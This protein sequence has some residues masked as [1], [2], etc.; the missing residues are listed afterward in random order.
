MTTEKEDFWK[1][2]E[3]REDAE[4]ALKLLKK[5]IDNPK[6]TSPAEL[7]V[8]KYKALKARERFGYYLAEDNRAGFVYLATNKAMSGLVKIG[9]TNGDV[10]ERM[11][12]LSSNT[13]VPSPFQCAYYC[14]VC[15]P[16]K[17]E[18]ILH[19]K[20]DFCRWSGNREFFK[21]DWRAVKVALGEIA[22]SYPK[23]EENA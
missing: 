11:R 10:N 12:E 7:A 9:M 21:V 1:R 13:G 22:K 2:Q 4:H 3:A 18:S 6:R 23:E 5:A 8:R 14:E 15:S 16:K 20:F 19:E 17:V